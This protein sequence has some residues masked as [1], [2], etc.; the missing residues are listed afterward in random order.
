MVLYHN[1]PRSR[2]STILMT[3]EIWDT[4]ASVLELGLDEGQI[5][6]RI[7]TP[8]EDELQSR[9]ELAES[10]KHYAEFIQ[11]FHRGIDPLPVHGKIA[12]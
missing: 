1:A 2:H 8:V 4:A 9:Y 7:T 3:A 10:R 5:R 6:A 12:V 11:A